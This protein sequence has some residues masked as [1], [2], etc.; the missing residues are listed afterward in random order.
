[1]AEDTL[2]TEEQLLSDTKLRHDKFLSRAKR[3]GKDGSELGLIVGTLEAQKVIERFKIIERYKVF[4]RYEYDAAMDGIAISVVDESGEYNYD[5]FFA[6]LDADPDVNWYEPDFKLMAPEAYAKYA[7][8][9]QVMPWG[10]QAV[11]ADQSWTASSWRKNKVH[12][13]VVDSGIDHD[14]LNVVERVDFVNDGATGDP[15]GHGTHVAG[16]IGAI[17]DSDHV[18]GVAPGVQIHDY[19]VLG[20]DGTTDVSVVLAAVERIT[21]EKLDNPNRAMVV[22]MS[23]GENVGTTGYTALDDAVAASIGAGVIYVIASGNYGVDASTV[24]PAHVR[25]AITVGAYSETNEHSWFSSNGDMIDVLAPGEAVLSLEAGGSLETLSGTSMA[26]AHVTGIV[27]RM[28]A[29][30]YKLSPSYVANLVASR[31]K[32]LV[33]GAPKGTTQKGATVVPCPERDDGRCEWG[34]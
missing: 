34:G 15:D 27:A 31:A 16:T 5:E 7:S 10:V 24:T 17:D 11:D 20:A 12:V 1:M 29:E 25:Q 8:T 2:E 13:Y 30:D 33:S 21:Q 4:E 23:L 3:S 18:V 32:G 14:D 26:A 28:L 22:N 19:R 9:N 6:M